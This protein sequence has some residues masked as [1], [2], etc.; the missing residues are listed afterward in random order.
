MDSYNWTFNQTSHNARA[1]HV[2]FMTNIC[3]D[4]LSRKL[5]QFR[6]P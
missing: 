5:L 3:F 1:L 2:I 6:T 4:F